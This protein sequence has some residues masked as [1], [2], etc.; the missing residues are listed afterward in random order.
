MARVWGSRGQMRKGDAI[1]AIQEGLGK[2]ESIEAML[3]RLEP[4][5]LNALSFIKQLGGISQAEALEIILRASGGPLPESPSHGREDAPLVRA[6][7]KRGLVMAEQANAYSYIYLSAGSYRVFADYRVLEVVGGPEIESFR[8]GHVDEQTSSMY[9]RPSSPLLDIIGLLRAV[10][11]M[12]G[13]RLTKGGK[14]RVIDM[15]R[16]ARL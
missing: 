10:E 7:I 4:F 1:R 11:G 15:R 13:L 16:L 6:L 2:A 3:S 14:V 9:R 8:M 12:G 5:E